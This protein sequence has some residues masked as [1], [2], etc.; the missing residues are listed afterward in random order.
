MSAVVQFATAADHA[1]ETEERLVDL[2]DCLVE[3][4]QRLDT[5]EACLVEAAGADPLTEILAR[6]DAFE[7][8]LA[9]L[10]TR[11]RRPP[12]FPITVIENI[13]VRADELS[14]ELTTERYERARGDRDLHHAQ[15]GF[16]GSMASFRQ[17][18]TAFNQRLDRCADQFCRMRERLAAVEA[19]IGDDN[20]EPRPS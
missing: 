19:R 15:Q 1:L 7:N 16:N 12:P 8:R 13:P 17:D 14:R 11:Q 6:I 20:R 3:L 9:R 2:V 5:L 4:G 18:M 10:E